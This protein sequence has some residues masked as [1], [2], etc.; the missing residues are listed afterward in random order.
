MAQLVG[1]TA[2]E[3]RVV[4][5]PAQIE[6]DRPFAPLP[7]RLWNIAKGAGIASAIQFAFSPTLTAGPLEDEWH[8]GSPGGVDEVEAM[9]GMAPEIDGASV[10]HRAPGQTVIRID[11]DAPPVPYL[12]AL[13]VGVND[14]LPYRSPPALQTLDG[15]GEI[16]P[17]ALPPLAGINEV[18]HPGLSMNPDRPL[19][20]TNL[21]VRIIRG[22][23]QVRFTTT[24][25]SRSKASSPPAPGVQDTKAR[26]FR[27]W[28]AFN[29]VVTAT[30]GRGSEIMD[31]LRV[32]VAST[33]GKTESG[34]ILPAIALERGSL[35]GVLSG[36]AD[37][38]YRVDVKSFLAGMFLENVSDALIA[39]FNQF[40]MKGLREAGYSLPVGVNALVTTGKRIQQMERGEAPTIGR[41]KD[42]PQFTKLPFAVHQPP[43]A[44]LRQLWR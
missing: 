35:V 6:L 26:T 9:L 11:Q 16:A 36:I 31:A 33:Y 15:V 28:L 44:E 42:G 37:G 3:A 12:G 30:Y 22:G 13:T 25:I 5:P 43:Q 34:L 18:A 21:E 10:M 7:R 38:T 39:K 32:L 17:E 29:Q 24:P 23:A 27:A 14:P 4:N 2:T 1:Q 19:L 41:Y 40:G 8:P 20:G